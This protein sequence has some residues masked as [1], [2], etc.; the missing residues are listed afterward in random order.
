[1]D[2]AQFTPAVIVSIKFSTHVDTSQLP[3]QPLHTSSAARPVAANAVFFPT[4][5][6]YIY[7]IINLL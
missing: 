2:T 7:E 5:I 1:M 4:L 3:S 6:I